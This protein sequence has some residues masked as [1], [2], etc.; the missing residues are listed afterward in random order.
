MKRILLMTTIFMCV[1]SL[2][3]AQERG[4]GQRPGGAGG[5]GGQGQFDPAAMIDRQVQ[6]LKDS[7]SLTDAQVPKVKEIVTKY[8]TES[9]AAM[10]KIR[11]SG[12][13]REAMTA[14]RT[15]IQTKQ[16]TE[17]KAL[18]TDAQKAK[19]DKYMANNAARMR[20]F[21]GQGGGGGRGPR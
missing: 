13:D 12:G 20:G 3:Q 18:L 9:M 10:T 4:S 16:S 19:Y 7:I 17:I 11:E 6:T 15:A 5:G 14:Q 8:Q 21:G 1:F 2:A